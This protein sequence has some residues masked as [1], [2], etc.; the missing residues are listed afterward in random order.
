MNHRFLQCINSSKPVLV[1][2]YADWCGPCKE[3]ASVIKKVKQGY[4][5][6]RVVKVNV[7]EF[8]QIA[9]RFKVQ[10]IPT[11][12]VF[13]KGEPLWSG[14]GLY[15]VDELRSLLSQQLVLRQV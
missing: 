13:M 8:P 5:G 7:D 10:R 2:F 3:M 4:K 11:L 14:E 1:D 9:S 15:S 6:L 12:M